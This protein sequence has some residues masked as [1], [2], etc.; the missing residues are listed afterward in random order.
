M[1]S[2]INLFKLDKYSVESLVNYYNKSND[3]DILNEITSRLE[4]FVYKIVNEFKNKEIEYKDLLQIGYAGLLVAINRF[5][6]KK[7]IKFSTFAYY[8]IKGEILHYIRDNNLINCPRWLLE[9]NKLFINFLK[10]FENKYSR[11]PTKKEISKGMNITIDG[12]DELIKARQSILYRYS[13][14]NIMDS[15]GNNDFNKKLIKSVNYSD[16]NLI[17][18]DK[19]LLWD[20]IDKLSGLKKKILILNYFMGYNQDEVGKKVGISQRSVS[21]YLKLAV[22]DLKGYML[23]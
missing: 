12:V 4:K 9:L 10:D 7:E 23:G 22:N 21:R 18:E 8:C 3:P 16:F 11:L 1:K 17:I 5:N 19:I 6:I 15:D 2:S 13:L 20:A 14:D